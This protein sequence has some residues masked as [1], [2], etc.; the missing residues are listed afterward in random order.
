TRYRKLPPCT[1][2]AVCHAARP[3]R[4]S[5]ATTSMCALPT[6]SAPNFTS[7]SIRS[8]GPKGTLARFTV[9]ATTVGGAAGIGV[10]CAQEPVA[11][12]TARITTCEMTRWL[13]CRLPRERREVSPCG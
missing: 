11:E 9:D 10:D 6:L 2:K 4:L 8:P 12:T 3:R 1:Q 5:S 13:T 7:Y